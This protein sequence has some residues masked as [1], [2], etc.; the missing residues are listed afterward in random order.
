MA[1]I[2]TN[3]ASNLSTMTG[4]KADTFNLSC[5]STTTLSLAAGQTLAFTP[6]VNH[7]NAGVILDLTP[8]VGTIDYSVKVQ[9][10]KNVAS[11]WTDVTVANGFASDAFQTLT[12]NQI[13]DSAADKSGDGWVIPFQWTGFAVT[14]V[15]STWRYNITQTGG[16]TGNWN[17]RTSNASAPFFIE[18]TGTA[19]APSSTN[20][21]LV[22]KDVLTIDTNF[23]AKGATGTGD[24]TNAPAIIICKNVNGP[25]PANV[26]NLVWGTGGSYTLTV[27]GL[28]VVSAH[29]GASAGTS[30]T[31]ITFANQGQISFI[32]PTVGAACGFKQASSTTANNGRKMS[33]QFY[34]AIP[35]VE[36]CI[37]NADS[38]VGSTTLT[39]TTDV[40]SW[41]NGWRV[42]ITRSNTQGVGDTAVYTLSGS[43]VFSGG[44]STITLTGALATNDRK[45]G[46]VVQL[47]DGFGFKIVG[48]TTTRP[49]FGFQ[50]ASNLVFSGCGIEE[51]GIGNGFASN[52]TAA[53]NTYSL[54]DAANRSQWKFQHGY[55]Y[56]TV[57]GANAALGNT[58][59]PPEGLLIDNFA[60]L[61]FGTMMNT[62]YGA[63][64]G[65]SVTLSNSVVA[66]LSQTTF[67]PFINKTIISGNYIHN[68]SCSLASSVI[69]ATNPTINNNDFY[70]SSSTTGAIEYQTVIKP[71]SISGNTYNNNLTAVFLNATT[72]GCVEQSSNYGNLQANTTDIDFAAGALVDYIILSASQSIN[73]ATA[74]LGGTVVGTKIG[75]T[76][77]NATTND[78]R[79]YLTYGLFQRTGTGLSD[80][81]VHTS[82][83]FAMRFQPTDSINLLQFAQTVPTG[84][85]Q[86]KTMTVTCWIYINNAAYYAGVHTNPQISI[87]YDNGTVVTATASNTAGSWQQLGL[88]FTPATTYG[89]ITITIQGAT[90]ATSTNAYFYLDDFNIAYPA[91]VSINLGGIDLWA[92]ALPIT[93]TIATFPSLGGVWDESLSAHTI[94]GTFGWFVKKLL[95]VAKFLGLK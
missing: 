57:G 78:D 49:T 46:A 77:Y 40:S 53:P 72:V 28:F 73:I 50:N 18:I 17:I 54:D 85:I 65:G 29:G 30:G 33:L 58:Q 86:N 36:R 8:S 27:N 55:L 26:S 43:P 59:P 23:T 66:A 69:A 31:P 93:P 84:N 80:T 44:V 47:M 25:T 19:Q 35:T 95:T 38:L 11:V 1:V 14:N 20:D 87:N 15:A 45:A 3:G 51:F 42:Y 92:N 71:L 82:G 6:T 63:S 60:M 37:T 90:D 88:T 41:Q 21:V 16:T 2:V 74:D 10:Q 89:Q 83:G 32:N 94:S 75:I 24:A 39:T 5:F 76:N 7:N 56:S 48:N 22:C 91:G 68:C 64:S 13:S 81:T 52:V 61:R 67:I 34:G 70:G 62:T 12:A 79:D 9:L 4:L